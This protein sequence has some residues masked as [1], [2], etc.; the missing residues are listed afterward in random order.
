MTSPSKRGRPSSLIFPSSLRILQ[1]VR[2]ESHDPCMYTSES[3]RRHGKCTLYL[4][5]LDTYLHSIARVLPVFDKHGK[6][7]RLANGGESAYIIVPKRR[8]PWVCGGRGGRRRDSLGEGRSRYIVSV[9][10]VRKVGFST[11]AIEREARKGG[12]KCGRKVS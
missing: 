8:T 3:T 2:Y 1:L 5:P 11:R 12:V 7:T 4:R 9:S 10:Y 6:L